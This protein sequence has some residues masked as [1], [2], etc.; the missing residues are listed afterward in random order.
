MV[1]SNKRGKFHPYHKGLK[2]PLIVLAKISLYIKKNYFSYMILVTGGTG[3]VGSHLLYHLTL[4]NDAVVA[5][6]RASSDLTMVK[7]VFAYYTNNAAHHFA[8]I[9]WQKADITDIS[10][11]QDIFVNTFEQVYHCAAMISFNSKDYYK[12]RNVNIKGTANLVNLSLAYCVKKFCFVSSIATIDAVPGQ[13]FSTEQNEWNAALKHHGY[14]ITKYGAEME[15]WRA[16]Q[17]GLD[18]VIVNP[19]VILGSGFWNS[20]S[21]KLFSSVAN[22]FNYYT[23]GITGFIGVEDVVK[24]MINLMASNVKN[25]RFVLVSQNLSFKKVLF[26]IAD[27]IGVRRPSIKVSKLMGEI[28]WR[29]DWFKGLFGGQRKLTRQT[30]KSAHHISRYSSE[31]VKSQLGI[32]LEPIKDV[33]ASVSK[34]YKKEMY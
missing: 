5:L 1:I 20:G 13:E 19:G 11:L 21:G 30:S 32:E 10:S 24:A 16:S 6:H 14:A 31:K 4:K 26:Q 17:E 8:K 33:I 28:A 23:E 12:L 9:I 34:N 2:F 15:V 22:G 29:L 18:V 27:H 25:E 3:L 7:R